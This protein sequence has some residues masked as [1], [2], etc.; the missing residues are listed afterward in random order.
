MLNMS[1]QEKSTAATL[2]ANLLVYGWY[3]FNMTHIALAAPVNE[4]PVA[5]AVIASHLVITIVAIVVI[6]IVSHI[7]IALHT[8]RQEGEVDDAGD[9]RDTLIDLRG[10]SRGGTILG[11]GV[12]VTIVVILLGYSQF[13][14][15][16]LLLLALVLSEVVKDVAKLIDYRR[17]F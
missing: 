16:N 12:V 5:I 3:F 4:K 2:A 13:W 8:Q 7:V 14:T 10:E 11:V 9:E 6:A 17:S 15:A 1:F